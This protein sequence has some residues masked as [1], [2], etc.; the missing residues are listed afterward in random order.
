MH[1]SVPVKF[2]NKK[3]TMTIWV[4]KFII[5]LIFTILI[6][7]TGFTKWFYDPVL[8]LERIYWVV[9]VVT[10]WLLLI[11]LQNL[12]NPCYIYFEDTDESL[13]FRYYPLRIISQKKNSV[14]I[15]KKD[16]LQFKTEKFFLGK[17][18]KLFLYQRFKKGVAKYP[19]ISL[20]AVN[21]N[22]IAKIKTLLRQYAKEK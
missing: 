22:D 1:K 21:R 20:S 17:Y 19:P 5:T 15:P 7:F 6:I 8:G 11:S 18:E 14:E 2:Q 10:F 9:I 4:N 3:N 13:I 12:R 16:F